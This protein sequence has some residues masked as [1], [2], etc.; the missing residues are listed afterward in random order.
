MTDE[1]EWIFTWG[2]DQGH[3][4][5]YTVIYG[6]FQSARDIMMRKY[7]PK[8]GFQYSSREAAGVDKWDLKEIK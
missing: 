7:G 5:C 2:F 3:D 8:W 1:Q 6:T 4:N